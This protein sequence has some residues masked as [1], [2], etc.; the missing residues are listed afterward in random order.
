MTRKVMTIGL[1]RTMLPMNSP[2]I[3]ENNPAMVQAQVSTR[4]IR[5]PSS[6]LRL[7]LL[8]KARIRRPSGV[9]VR[10]SAI[11]TVRTSVRTSAS[12]RV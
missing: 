10:R 4:F 6:A 7:R 11:A 12:R 8:C 5:T 1:R 9:L 3:P 2:A